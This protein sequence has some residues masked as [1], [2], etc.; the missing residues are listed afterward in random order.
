MSHDGRGRAAAD[1]VVP[2]LSAL[3]LPVRR[4][5][6]SA[7][8][9]GRQPAAR[10]GRGPARSRSGGSPGARCGV[11]HTP[12]RRAGRP[13]ARGGG[14]S[15]A[16]AR[17]ELTFDGAAHTF[18][19]G[20]RSP[21]RGSFRCGVTGADMFDAQDHLRGGRRGPVGRRGQ[22][23]AGGRARRARRPGRALPGRRQRRPHG[24]HR[25][26]P[27]SSC[28]RSPP[29][30]CIPGRLRRRQRCGAR[31]GD[32]LRRARPARRARA[33]T[34]TGRIFVSDRAH[35]VLPY[36]KLLDA[37]S[38]KSQKHRHDGPGH[39]PGLRGQ[40]RPPRA[41]GSPICAT[42]TAPARSW[43]TGWTA[44]TACWR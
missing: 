32:L 38:E 2:R 30:S 33:S 28:A 18:A 23:Q 15:G 27:S 19:R 31:A 29:A 34:P 6:A 41:S 37:A 43:P 25:R 22:G 24:G 21:A 20:F 12:A 40:V 14:A 36:H 10:A 5:T 42:S 17:D 7:R 35:L 16:R 11:I 26:R 44:P 4:P 8:H 39:R 1:A 9:S 3:G 13:V